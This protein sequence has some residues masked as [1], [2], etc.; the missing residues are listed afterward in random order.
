MVEYDPTFYNKDWF[1]YLSRFDSVL[2]TALYA[3]F[4]HLGK[5]SSF[6]D[7]GCGTGWLVKVCY[8]MGIRPSYGIELSPDV[9]SVF[10]D[11]RTRLIY[12][13]DLR[14]PIHLGMT[15]DMVWCVEVAEHLPPEASE[16][17]CNTLAEHTG[18]VLV[19]TAASVGQGGDQHVNEQP[20]EFWRELLT[21]RG[22]VY[23]AAST[24]HLRETWRWTTGPC[25]WMPANV[26]IFRAGDKQP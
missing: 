10:P 1:M 21:A 3:A 23:D 7:V 17:L 13:H 22:L 19:F 16:V 12:I 11:E 4:A 9:K 15:F 6:L 24:E 14:K 25:F 26:Q 8:A 18:K 20:P 5:P 2:E